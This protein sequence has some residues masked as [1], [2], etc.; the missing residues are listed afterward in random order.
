V[1]AELIPALAVAVGA[2]SGGVAV[3]LA[4]RDHPPVRP[5]CPCGHIISAHEGDTGR[6]TEDVRRDHYTKD[7]SR[8]GFEWVRCAC[9][10]YTGPEL[11]SMLSAQPF[12]TRGVLTGHEDRP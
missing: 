8:N 2:V 7:G 3:R 12:V 11:I 9:L 4:R 1:I 10:H 6:C 5:V